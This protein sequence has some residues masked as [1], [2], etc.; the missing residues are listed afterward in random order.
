MD[1]LRICIDSTGTYIATSNDD[2]CIRL[3]DYYNG[4]L[5]CKVLL[6]DI[7][8]GMCFTP[9]NTHFITVTSEGLIIIWKLPNDINISI[10]KK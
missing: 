3:R 1:N 5:I 6:G 10:D 2:K 4:N 9:N 8:T 7:C